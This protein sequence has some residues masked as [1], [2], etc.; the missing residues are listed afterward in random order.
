[1]IEK[2]PLISAL[3]T[4]SMLG[5]S[6]RKNS[7]KN[8]ACGEHSQIK[9]NS[10]L[11]HETFSFVQV[12]GMGYSIQICKMNVKWSFLNVDISNLR[13][14]KCFR[15]F[16]SL[17]KMAGYSGLGA[18]SVLNCRSIWTAPNSTL[19]LHWK[20]AGSSCSKHLIKL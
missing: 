16:V 1:M 3:I 7:Q 10:R 5:H 8:F 17:R 4:K 19:V 20:C 6:V 14:I 12:T 13:F 15:L 9:K 2:L 18:D 11:V